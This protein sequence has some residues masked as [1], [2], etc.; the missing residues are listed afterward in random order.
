MSAERCDLCGVEHDSLG[1]AL[2]C[3]AELFGDEPASGSVSVRGPSPGVAAI[4]EERDQ[5]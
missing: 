4:H 5:R 1:A 3:C 2:R